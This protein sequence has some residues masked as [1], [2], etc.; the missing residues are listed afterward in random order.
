MKALKTG[1]LVVGAVMTTLTPQSKAETEIRTYMCTTSDHQSY[2]I[3]LNI[4]D[5]DEGEAIDGTMTWRGKTFRDL[6]QVEGCRYRYLAKH[7]DSFAD[8]CTSAQGVSDLT[9][10]QPQHAAAKFN[11]QMLNR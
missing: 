5:N 9:I 7:D 4:I 1:L 11:C 2:P 10:T 6:K 8:L 3:V